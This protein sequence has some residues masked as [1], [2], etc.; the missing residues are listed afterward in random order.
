MP[1]R[2]L[3]T[4]AMLDDG[5]STNDFDREQLIGL[6]AGLPDGIAVL[7]P[8]GLIAFA[9]DELGRMLGRTTDELLGSSGLDLIHPDELARALD[10]I[11]FSSQFPDR[12]AVVPYRIRRGDGSWLPVELKSRPLTGPGGDSLV[13]V[14][15]DGTT[16]TTLAGALGSVAASRPL[17]E[18]ARQLALAVGSRWPHTGVAITF[19]EHT[20]VDAPVPEATDAG[21]WSEPGSGRGLVAHHLP[22]EL[23]AWAT[24]SD[25][26]LPWSRASLERSV[27]IAERDDLPVALAA[28][29]ARHGF[30]ACAAAPVTDPG[31]APACLIAWFDEPMVAHLEFAHAITEVTELLALALERRFHLRQ[32]HDAARHDPLTGLPNR[33]GFFERLEADLAVRSAHPDRVTV[34]LLFIDLDGFKPINDTLG[35]DAGDALLVETARRLRTIARKAD[36][37]A[38]LGGDEFAILLADAGVPS[39]V[40]MAC[41]RILAAFD[42]PVLHE[43]HEMRTSPSIGVSLFPSDGTTQDA[44]YKSADLALYEAKRSG[45]HTWRFAQHKGTGEGGEG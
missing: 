25:A 5:H 30:G 37:V 28:E 6:A 10:G 26:D 21:S 40:D 24:R 38:R 39:A 12:T 8:D 3:A 36:V 11:V 31:G 14:V 44:L 23:A 7:G 34:A 18:T 1:A 41:A 20:Q 35:H 9:N 16:R 17:A 42:T 2:R 29:A 33:M 22:D 15:R 45:R 13:L 32:L 19:V 43:G 4:E 27:V